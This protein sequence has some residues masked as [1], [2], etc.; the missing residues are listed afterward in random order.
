MFQT[1]EADR[2]SIFYVICYVTFL[3]TIKAAII[4]RN[5][6]TFSQY[7]DLHRQYALFASFIRWIA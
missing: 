3:V 2:F 4:F 5:K 6:Y 1:L 7:L